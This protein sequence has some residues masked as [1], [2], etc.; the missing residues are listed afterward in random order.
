MTVVTTNPLAGKPAPP[1]LRVDLPKL[2]TAYYTEV[3]D[4]AATW[5]ASWTW[6]YC[7]AQSCA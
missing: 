4:P 1:E 7:G 2:V 6:P 3:P 5:R